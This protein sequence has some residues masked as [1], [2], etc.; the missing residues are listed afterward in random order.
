MAPKA[1]IEILVPRLEQLTLWT[2]MRMALPYPQHSLTSSSAITTM[3]AE[4][5]ERQH[6]AVTNA[7]A[8]H[9]ETP[10]AGDALGT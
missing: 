2:P 6:V 7:G 5:R 4:R 1:A 8:F 3:G 10:T 9:R